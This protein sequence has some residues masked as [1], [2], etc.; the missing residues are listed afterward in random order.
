MI[1]DASH[2]Q[3]NIAA[4]NTGEQARPLLLAGVGRVA[5][6]LVIDTGGV[7]DTARTDAVPVHF[8]ELRAKI[9]AFDSTI[10]TRADRGGHD[11]EPQPHPANAVVQCSPCAGRPAPSYTVRLRVVCGTDDIAA[12]GLAWSVVAGRSPVLVDS[13]PCR[14]AEEG[15][16]DT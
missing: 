8:A 6:D 4:C 3:L 10:R 16:D 11:R 13:P 14:P 2:L 9:N 15:A 7:P 1:F 5:A 12:P